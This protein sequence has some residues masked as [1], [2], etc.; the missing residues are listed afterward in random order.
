MKGITIKFRGKAENGEYVYGDLKQ[1]NYNESAFYIKPRKKR[2]VY[3]DKNS[4][5]QLVGYDVNRNEIY[6]GDELVDDDGNIYRVCLTAMFI[7]D[8]K[9]GFNLSPATVKLHQLALKDANNG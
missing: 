3:V 5:A 1:G 7:R 4:V 8:G 2:P 6:E 9:L